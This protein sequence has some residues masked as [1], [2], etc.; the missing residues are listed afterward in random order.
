MLEKGWE[1]KAL[2]TCDFNRQKATAIYFYN[3]YLVL[4]RKF[5]SSHHC[6]ANEDT[7]DVLSCAGGN[8]WKA[9]YLVNLNHIF[10]LWKRKPVIK[11]YV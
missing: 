7:E 6:V 1:E 8:C 3:A 2:M 11:I 4:A 9:D 10:V 5:A